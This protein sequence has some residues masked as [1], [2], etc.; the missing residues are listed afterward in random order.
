MAQTQIID[1]ATSSPS[2]FL[3]L[4]IEILRCIA[5]NLKKAEAKNLALTC[6]NL[7]EVGESIIWRQLSLTDRDFAHL[8]SSPCPSAREYVP[9]VT[10]SS[11]VT[12]TTPSAS[13]SLLATLHSLLSAQPWRPAQLRSLSLDLRY[14]LPSSLSSIL[15]SA[16]ALEHLEIRTPGP[17][18]HSTSYSLTAT[19][20]LLRSLSQPLVSLRHLRIDV[21][22]RW[23]ETLVEIVRQAPNLESL[24]IL[25][26]PRR[27]SG[28]VPPIK[29][30][31]IPT[32]TLPRLKELIVDEMEQSFV[33]TLTPLVEAAD[34]LEAVALR[35]HA[36]RWKADSACPLMFAL[37][38]KTRLKRLECTSM[39]FPFFVRPGFE[40]VESLSM[41][42]STD[43][44]FSSSKRVSP[45]PRLSTT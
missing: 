16:K 4:P 14:E 27:I 36:H 2:Y 3:A 6:V 32:S 21:R 12:V 11:H 33:A 17:S 15:N 8:I 7:Q 10:P 42:W 26:H 23:N 31:M 40:A 20:D 41:L 43:L 37:A 29:S 35:D 5:S 19:L 18:F 30:R 39:L 22:Y 28:G 38:S 45:L 24:H 25:S 9:P 34:R 1:T 44:V 13:R